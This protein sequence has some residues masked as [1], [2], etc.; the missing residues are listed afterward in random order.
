MNRLCAALL[1]CAI[2]TGLCA[3]ELTIP[4]VWLRHAEPERPVLSNLDPIP[5]DR[6]R[7]GAQVAL[8]DNLTTGRFLGQKYTLEIVEIAPEAAPV[9]AARAALAASPFLV[10]DAP[11]ASQLAIAD[12]AE[13]Q[14]ASLF[15]ASSSDMALRGADCRAN[16]LH[17]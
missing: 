2:G 8:D 11:A 6:G 17:T 13:A 1:A 5:E 14:G 9:A 3:Q 15:N 7:A 4:M 16:L 12:L 10:L